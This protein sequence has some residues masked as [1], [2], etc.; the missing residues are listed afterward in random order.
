M[1]KLFVILL[2]LSIGPLAFAEYYPYEEAGIGVDIP[3]NWSVNF[4]DNEMEADAPDGSASIYL[5]IGSDSEVEAA[6]GELERSVESSVDNFEDSGDMETFSLN[7]MEAVAGDGTGLI[8]G[9]PVELGVMV[10]RTP[11]DKA[12]LVFCRRNQ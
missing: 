9:V 8:D 2:S 10:V 6:W 7:G 4:N 11:T 12:L 5:R 1:K 3:D